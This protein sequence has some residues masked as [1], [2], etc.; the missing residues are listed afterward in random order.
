M[1][2]E[3]DQRTVQGERVQVYSANSS[4]C[5]SAGSRSNSPA[6]AQRL[7]TH[8]WCAVS[9][10]RAAGRALC[11]AGRGSRAPAVEGP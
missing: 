10:T 6:L 1:R 9:R 4:L 8:R 7:D 3:F 5:G 11:N 2:A